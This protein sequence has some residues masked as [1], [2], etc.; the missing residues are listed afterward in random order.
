M[1]DFKPDIVL[2]DWTYIACVLMAEVLGVPRISLSMTP[3]LDPLL[4]SLLR[5]TGPQ[6][7]SKRD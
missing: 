1:Q 6:K 7:F 5:D 2:G 4:T 3:L